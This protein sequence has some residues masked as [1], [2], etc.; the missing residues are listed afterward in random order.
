M[1]GTLKGRLLII[2]L[3]MA[4]CVIALWQNGIKLGLDLQGGMHLA[5]EVQDPNGTLTAEQRAD[6]TDQNLQ[7]LRNR[8]DQFGVTEPNIQKIGTDR[9]IVELPGITDEE[10]AKDVIEQQAFLEWKLVLPSSDLVSALPRMDRAVVA[11]L[12]EEGLSALNADDSAAATA[13]TMSSVGEQQDVRD[14]LFAQVDPAADTLGADTAAAATG[15]TQSPLSSLILQGA[16][17]DGEFAIVRRVADFAMRAYLTDKT[18][19]EH[20]SNNGR[21]QI[22]FDAHVHETCDR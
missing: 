17:G 13:D 3:V 18:L 5:L 9:I 12:G 22:G 4:A 2:A 8:I 20:G 19:R 15:P 16:G 7:I 1:F 21:H 6:F 14:L 10:R 11:A